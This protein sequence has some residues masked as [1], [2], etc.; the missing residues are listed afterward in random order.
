[1]ERRAPRP[2]QRGDPKRSKRMVGLLAGLLLTSTVLAAGSPF[3]FGGDAAPSRG[4][5]PGTTPPEERAARLHGG[6]LPS[7]ALLR[8]MGLPADGRPLPTT[9]AEA[10]ARVQ[11]DP[12][13]LPWDPATLL[14]LAAADHGWAETAPPAMRA[15]SDLAGALHGYAM[16]VGLEPPTPDELAAVQA[17]P[18]VLQAP[19]IGL[20]DALTLASHLQREAL[21]G[22][23]PE[24][25]AFLL[26]N[27]PEIASGTAGPDVH[28]RA[29]A[30]ASRV[31]LG[32]SV[33]AAVVLVEA[34][35]AAT[36]ALEVYV[37]ETTRAATETA[38]AQGPAASED[39]LRPRSPEEAL[40]E[41]AAI[42]RS[43]TGSDALG[44]VAPVPLPTALQE[45]AAVFNGVP[46]PG[47]L[48]TANALPPELSGALGA[49]VRAYALTAGLEPERPA[50]AGRAALVLETIAD[51]RPVLERWSFLLAKAPPVTRAPTPE[52]GER[53]VLGL[54]RE[55]RGASSEA[56]GLVALAAGTAGHPLPPASSWT[57]PDV[58]SAGAALH[59]W[60]ARFHP[61]LPSSE[62]RA[63]AASLAGMPAPVQEAIATILWGQVQ[64]DRR[65]SGAQADVDRLARLDEARPAIVAAL[66]G[67]TLSPAMA[68]ALRDHVSLTDAVMRGL[69][70][71]PASIVADATDR[72]AAL[73]TGAYG[74][75]DAHDPE[76]PAPAP[77]PGSSD[78]GRDVWFADPT[79]TVLVTGFGSTT[80]PPGHLSIHIDLGG[81]DVYRHNAG[82]A[83]AAREQ[84]YA[85]LLDLGGNDR[86]NT[87]RP[88][89]QGAAIGSP[90]TTIDGALGAAPV[91][92]LVD[93]AGDDS[94][95]AGPISQGAAYGGGLGMLV[96]ADG[97]DT[98]EVT[99]ELEPG[100]TYDV[101]GGQ[102]YALQGIGDAGQP[103]VASI[104]LLVEGGG[105]DR[106][107]TPRGLGSA[108]TFFTRDAQTTSRAAVALMLEAGGDD[109]YACEAPCIGEGR[110]ASRT[111][112]LP[113]CTAACTPA[114][115]FLP[116]FPLRVDQEAQDT[117]VRVAIG[118]F[119]DLA[120]KD[121]Y[122]SVR[123]L[124]DGFRLTDHGGR[125]GFNTNA[126]V[127]LAFN[128]S[129][130]LDAAAGDSDQDGYLD[131]IEALLG[132]DPSE[133]TDN[134]HEDLLRNLRLE[135]L[136]DG[137]DRDGDCWSD[138]AEL[139][140]GT[141]PEEPTSH[142]FAHPDC[143]SAP[144]GFLVDL[145][146]DLTLGIGPTRPD[147]PME[148]VPFSSSL[149]AGGIQPIEHGG[150]RTDGTVVPLLAIGDVG[151]TL[152]G[153]PY[154]LAIDLGGDDVYEGAVGAARNISSGSN[155][156]SLVLPGLALDLDGNDTYL[157]RQGALAFGAGGA[158]Q[159]GVLADLAG[160]DEYRVVTGLGAAY[161]PGSVG[162]LL[163]VGGDDERTA[164]FRALGHVLPSCV[165]ALGERPELPCSPIDLRF[166]LFPNDDALRT[167]LTADPRVPDPAIGLFLDTSGDDRTESPAQG[168]LSTADEAGNLYGAG[169]GSR[170]VSS[171]DSA[172]TSPD[173]AAFLD[174]DGEDSYLVTDPTVLERPFESQGF[175]YPQVV[176]D[177]EGRARGAALFLDVGG[178]DRYQGRARNGT[179]HSQSPL[180]NDAFVT[181]GITGTERGDDSPAVFADLW[182]PR[183]NRSAAGLLYA[184][185]G[186]S[187]QDEG[188]GV[189]IA[190]DSMLDGQTFVLSLPRFDIYVGGPGTDRFTRT[191][192][193]AVDLGGDDLYS[194]PVGGALGHT[195][196]QSELPID[197]ALALDIGGDDTYRVHTR[198]PQGGNG[199]G[200]EDQ[201]GRLFVGRAHGAGV[202]GVGVHLD[203]D[204]RNHFNVTVDTGS[205]AQHRGLL[206]SQGAGFFGVGLLFTEA[207]SNLH[208]AYL[209]SGLEEQLAPPAMGLVQGAATMGVGVLA[210][211]GGASRDT[212]DATLIPWRL[213][214][215]ATQPIFLPAVRPRLLFSQ[216]S[217]GPVQLSASGTIGLYDGIGAGVLLD[218]SGDDAYAA[219]P[220]EGSQGKGHVGLIVDLGGRNAFNGERAPASE[221]P[222]ETAPVAGEGPTLEGTTGLRPCTTLPSTTNLVIECPVS[223]NVDRVLTILL[224]PTSALP[225]L[226]GSA[227]GAGILG[228]RVELLEPDC[229]TVLADSFSGR[230][231]ILDEVC[232]RVNVTGSTLDG[233][234]PRLDDVTF[235]IE[236]GG[237]PP[238]LIDRLPGGTNRTYEL[239]WDTSTSNV[240]DGDQVLWV[241]AT[242]PADAFGETVTASS[243]P[244][245]TLRQAR[246]V[247]LDTP[248][249]LALTA[250]PEWI[251]PGLLSDESPI[252]FAVRVLG[253]D[254]EST[255]DLDLAIAPGGCTDASCQHPLG[256]I[257]H[258][259]AETHVVTFN[260]TA[261]GGSRLGDGRYRLVATAIDRGPWGQAGTGSTQF[262]IDGVAPGGVL[263]VDSV[264]N[265]TTSS[266]AGFLVTWQTSDELG[267]VSHV[268]LYVRR[269]ESEWTAWRSGPPNGEDRWGQFQDGETIQFRMDVTDEAGNV[270]VGTAGGST[271]VDLVA[272]LLSEPRVDP[273][274]VRSGEPVVFSVEAT[275]ATQL[276]SAEVLIDGRPHAL[277]TSLLG[278]TATSMKRFRLTYAGWADVTRELGRTEGLNAS[279]DEGYAFRFVVRDAARNEATTA[280]AAVFID[281]ISPTLLAT[282][283]DYPRGR[284]AAPGDLVALHVE[285]A[286]NFGLGPVHVN[287]TGFSTT[288][289]VRLVPV[290]GTRNHTGVFVIDEPVVSPGAN[291]TFV[292]ADAAGNTV[293]KSE[294]LRV[295][296][297][298]VTVTTLD[299]LETGPTSA[300]LAWTTAEPSGGTIILSDDSSGREVRAETSE[301]GT[302][303]VVEIEGL[304]PA[305][306]YAG[307]IVPSNEAGR[308]AT[309]RAFTLTTES[310]IEIEP[311]APLPGSAASG[312]VLVSWE[313]ETPTLGPLSYNVVF[314]NENGAV[315]VASIAGK[316]NEPQQL[317]VPTRGLPDG[318]YDVRIEAT[319]SLDRATAVISDVL[320]D[321]TPPTVRLLDPVP[322][323]TAAVGRV[324]LEAFVFDEGAGLDAK[325]VA[326][327]VDGETHLPSSLQNG[328]A[329]AF[330]H[331][332]RTGEHQVHVVARDLTGNLAEDGGPVTLDAIAPEGPEVRL[333]GGRG[334]VRPGELVPIRVRGVE[335]DLVAGR[336]AP[337]PL[338]RTPVPLAYESGWFVGALRIPPNAPDRDYTLH[339]ELVDAAGLTSATPFVLVVD[340]T[341]PAILGA[342]L[343]PI[344]P[345]RARVA[346][347]ADEPVL[348]AV[349]VGQPDDEA[350]TFRSEV[351]QRAP[352]LVIEGLVPSALHRV[353]LVVSDPAGNK[354]VLERLLTMPRDELAPS[355]VGTVTPVVTPDGAVSLSWPP[356]VDNGAV[357][358]YRVQRAEP[359]AAPR[360]VGETT[361]TR[362]V[363]ERAESGRTYRY[364]VV[365]RDVAGNEGGGSD[366]VEVVPVA[367][368]RLSNG[369]VTPEQAGAGTPFRFEVLYHGPLTP[370]PRVEVV[371]DGVAHRMTPPEATSCRE[372]CLF[373]LEKELDVVTLQ[374]GP[375]SYSF[376]AL[377]GGILVQ[378]PPGGA[379]VSGPLVTA[380]HQTDAAGLP[381][382]MG[383][384]GAV[385]VL[386]GAGVGLVR[387]LR[388]RRSA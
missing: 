94:Y 148:Q 388:G 146:L 369:A 31:D 198:E 7:S 81:D 362:F 44:A 116:T 114:E 45:L 302:R 239:L 132:H 339:A 5:S 163:D 192:R 366:P 207:T 69:L 12:E 71:E 345:V 358:S 111:E 266:P 263:S 188:H 92:L 169:Q 82:G 305:T 68:S 125:L 42:L 28:E 209:H 126:Q 90:L 368:S 329:V 268:S 387:Y 240:T 228:L 204:G 147:G 334:A 117:G 238:V 141:D 143:E 260:G 77:P 136:V 254:P 149:I 286:D 151:T 291:V 139:R 336:I 252:T 282:R 289:T 56:A 199:N 118:T 85:V 272:P 3:L 301:I 259:A 337:G 127:D 153:E 72:A 160:S 267:N 316:R 237:A 123:G 101:A 95:V 215:T 311:T 64:A 231:A 170:G 76:L 332:E 280:D 186:P 338:S 250:T 264:Q 295:A 246:S 224:D 120:G 178:W 221:T 197:V 47:S 161:G 386:A 98:Y 347:S 39:R 218:R 359:G 265:R 171:P 342:L 341:P 14:R 180:K 142:P 32:K 174:L 79:G 330:V 25:R 318:L 49:I 287:V 93:L 36:P 166:I 41:T 23:T 165:V 374:S 48:D 327:V 307:L 131:G 212:Y 308:T 258:P 232:L 19:L 80:L 179:V 194:A 346:L 130:F 325:E 13:A 60:Y 87:T 241:E 274:F 247:H 162:V 261:P 154:A 320:L 236:R 84:R 314:L 67:H 83:G 249:R 91:G 351:P 277:S 383:A 257:T 230:P 385:L 177:S 363:D 172:R 133:T 306:T 292:V 112:M 17:V 317:R 210:S 275:D 361:E 298:G 356:A 181:H 226:E 158:G 290:P 377:T 253:E 382:A 219:D 176:E 135:A 105:S 223:D 245:W 144:S 96:D 251:N 205:N 271:T 304:D 379:P 61:D 328:T 121:S 185:L 110:W 53:A 348:V 46:G 225:R 70:F 343:E 380:Q 167:G 244:L 206:A 38:G 55:A 234:P 138:A 29:A 310:L 303:H 324:R 378:D 203:L 309:G 8:E 333:P 248:P 16:S 326:F 184:L 344:D 2:P 57:G 190:P 168:I 89:A 220:P 35:Q 364:T 86:Y 376:R 373:T 216:G 137:E 255:I 129:I 229:T 109:S 222:L 355:A 381:V 233:S 360:V 323:G 193:L 352:T 100:T 88:G 262:G 353:T 113:V 187:V 322:G 294:L 6:A 74:P 200:A 196:N 50:A 321:N 350:R 62:R 299:V 20:V 150:L 54:A 34:A 335:G 195:R 4:S 33:A 1:M 296:T 242:V 357:A 122:P 331:M 78:P 145:S 270:A 134:V 75:S 372:G 297:G 40:R 26:E 243:D 65:A 43:R 106:Y 293:E 375:H 349:H 370:L 202:L 73:L 27:A 108:L 217:V 235:W 315:P 66:T 183:D 312:T 211:A 11:A 63:S 21:A 285:A 273:Q 365:A 59:A 24:E 22:I 173:L 283:I 103:V 367:R 107:V 140:F 279:R 128:A 119:L 269:G 201:V 52:A 97:T 156:R 340:G 182:A 284:A 18:G 281:D 164:G 152:F 208:E 300:V 157:H 191:A 155:P 384:A 214:S 115:S 124:N 313:V 175:A 37:A 159:Y 227:S 102:G 288:E 104:A 30:I 99:G 9:L 256:N 276:S 371:I 319:Q 58:P 51:V 15:S 213:P 278:E 10:L 354:A 189:V